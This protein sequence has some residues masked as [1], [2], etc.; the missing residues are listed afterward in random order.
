MYRFIMV[1]MDG[2]NYT[3]YNNHLCTY[4]NT[5]YVHV[6]PPVGLQLAYLPAQSRMFR[7]GQRT[8]FVNNGVYFR[9]RHAL[10]VYEVVARPRGHYIYS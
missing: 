2:V 7:V 10:G 3:F 6:I 1:L 5:G 9:Y 8:Y 4:T